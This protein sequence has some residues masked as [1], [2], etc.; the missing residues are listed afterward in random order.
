M[1]LPRSLARFNRRVTNRILGSLPRRLS[2]FVTVS[3]VG[4]VTGR[5]Y[6]VLLASF[7]TPTGVVLTPTYGPQA[8][9][10]KNLFQAESFRMDRRGETR[11]FAAPRLVGREEAWPHLP[12]LVR[13]AMRVLR[14]QDF[15]VA[16]RLDIADG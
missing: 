11:V 9:W 6:T 1:P 14:I 13:L 3:H 16:D 15:V 4:R 10:V 2:P 7:D 5:V 8:D 12:R